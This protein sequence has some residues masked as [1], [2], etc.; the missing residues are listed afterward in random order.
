MKKK[1]IFS[2]AIVIVIGLLICI[3]GYF[4]PLS[5]SNIASENSEIS[6]ILN[7]YVVENGVADITVAEYKDITS[8]QKS[9][10]LTVMEGYTYKRT[11]GTIFSDGSMTGIG[12]K[13]LS[14]YAFDEDSS[15]VYVT[16]SGKIVVDNKNYYMEN[17]ERF[18]AQIIDI[19]E[20]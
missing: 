16:S 6:M 1:T 20:Q 10:I 4:K 11:F 18:I 3:N 2:V 8:E 12:K 9:A 15:T 5:F 7:E 17:A 19:M 13:M 14:I